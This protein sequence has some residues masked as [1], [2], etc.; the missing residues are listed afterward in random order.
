MVY[1]DNSKL[2][3]FVLT[4]YFTCHGLIRIAIGHPLTA[5][6]MAILGEAAQL[7][8]HYDGAMP[9]YPW[10][11]RGMLAL[12]G[13]QVI[14]LAV[15]K[16][17]I[18]LVMSLAVYGAVRASAAAHWAWSAT[19]CLVFLPQIA[20]T[21]QHGLTAPVLATSL[22]ALTILGAVA[23][24]KKKTMIRYIWMGFL[25]G[26][27][28]ISDWSYLCFLTALIIAMTTQNDY[29][30][31]LTSFRIILTIAAAIGVAAM[32]FYHLYGN[33]FVSNPFAEVALATTPEEGLER[34]K[35]GYNFMQTGIMF[36]AI[37][38]IGV[39]VTIYKGLGPRHATKPETS[40]LRDLI[41]RIVSVGF[42]MFLAMAI[43]TGQNMVEF[44]DIQPIMFLTAPMAVLYLYPLLT[45]QAHRTIKTGAAALA[46]LL[47]V[48]S[49]A[50]YA[51][52]LHGSNPTAQ[53]PMLPPPSESEG[54]V[55]EI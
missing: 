55:T 15:L 35:V 21:S 10:M 3:V 32:P 9:L 40:A 45:T 52:G 8:W 42:L 38:L 34:V 33:G 7:K 14:A 37:L 50:Y 28:A 26:C 24:V 6:E 16:N 47:L 27:G 5:D 29:R 11:Q 23:V 25:V 2:W 19:I 20:W 1:Q 4:I 31:V 12:V 13:D 44:A 49:P 48:L 51:F 36:V 17:L 22:A 18:L 46:M 53:L 39:C 43:A 41:A 54:A 30:R